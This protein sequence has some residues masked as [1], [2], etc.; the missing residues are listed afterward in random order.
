[1][2][3]FFLINGSYLFMSEEGARELYLNHIQDWILSLLIRRIVPEHPY[4]TS[5]AKTH[6]WIIAI[7]NVTRA[8]VNIS[9]VTESHS[10]ISAIRLQL[11]RRNVFSFRS[12]FK[13]VK[14]LPWTPVDEERKDSWF[15]R[16][17]KAAAGLRFHL[18][19][20]S[21][22]LFERAIGVESERMSIEADL[23]YVLPKSSPHAGLHHLSIKT[24]FVQLMQLDDRLL[25]HLV[26]PP[27]TPGA[28]IS[29]P[30]A[31]TASPPAR[32]RGASRLMIGILVFLLVAFLV[33]VVVIIW[34]L[35]YCR[36]EHKTRE[37][38]FR[39]SKSSSRKSKS[40]SPL[41]GK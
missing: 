3:V 20:N 7:A 21:T 40:S 33:A 9:L 19:L 25:D 4:Y 6:E 24:V 35:I 36:P 38:S 14:G 32:K 39:R 31:S 23:S 11:Q 10:P 2:H 30:D 12:C 29:A 13:S 16:P 27:T 8:D 22:A 5:D 28:T 1:M 41:R 37:A 17:A 26:A 34:L 18:M 15:P